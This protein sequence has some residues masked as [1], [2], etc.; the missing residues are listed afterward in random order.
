MSPA[1][2]WLPKPR[3]HGFQAAADYLS[4][5]MPAKR[6]AGYLARGGQQAPRVDENTDIPRVLA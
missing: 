4:L 5:V 1:V 3:K 6:A 2:N